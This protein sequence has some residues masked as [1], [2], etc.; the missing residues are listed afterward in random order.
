MGEPSGRVGPRQGRLKGCHECPSMPGGARPLMPAPPSPA[1]NGVDLRDGVRPRRPGGRTGLPPCPQPVRLDRF[2]W[3]LWQRLSDLGVGY[4]DYGVD[5]AV[6]GS[7]DPAD[8]LPTLRYTS[9]E[10]W[11]IYRWAR[12]GGRGD[13][14]LADLCRMLVSAPHWPTAGAGFSW[15]DHEILRRARRG[16]GT[17]SPSNW[18]AWSTSH[19]LA[20]VLA[21]LRHPDEEQDGGPWHFRARRSGSVPGGRPAAGR[22]TEPGESLL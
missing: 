10:A 2:D 18:L 13:E 4:G 14:R 22:D 19:H 7:D 17:G 1:V 16:A 3:Q 15:G 12:R 21:A 5:C 9:D 20:Q 8:R 6:P 11:W